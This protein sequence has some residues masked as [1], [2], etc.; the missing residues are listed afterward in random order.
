MDNLEEIVADLILCEFSD[1]ETSKILSTDQQT[2]RTQAR[3]PQQQRIQQ[4]MKNMR[5]D[6]RSTDPLIRKKAL[7]QKQLAQVITQIRQKQEQN[8]NSNTVDVAGGG[9]NTNTNNGGL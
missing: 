1:Y 2:L 4:N 9:T 7:L 3:V 8:N 6:M 5:N